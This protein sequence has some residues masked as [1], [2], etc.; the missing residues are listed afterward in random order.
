M[1]THAHTEEEVLP[2][3]QLKKKR[4]EKKN[5]H[6]KPLSDN[7]TGDTHPLLSTQKSSVCH[8]QH[9]QYNEIFL[10]NYN[11]GLSSGFS[12]AHFISFAP[13]LSV[14]CVLVPLPI[15]TST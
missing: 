6:P 7:D 4:K 5:M 10:S 9:T 3:Q 14:L 2:L 13:S 11:C 15:S 1:C 12:L 8:F